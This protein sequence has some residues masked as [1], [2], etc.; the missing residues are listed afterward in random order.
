MFNNSSYREQA[1]KARL[2]KQQEVDRQVI[3]CQSCKKSTYFFE[4]ECLQFKLHHTTVLGQ[5]AVPVGDSVPYILLKCVKCGELTEP[6]IH[7]NGRDTADKK[8]DAFLD[9]LEDDS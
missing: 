9:L 8:Y 2:N 7:R 1:E 4:I 3:R 6:K 5:R